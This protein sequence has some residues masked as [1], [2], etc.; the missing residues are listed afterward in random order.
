MRVAVAV[1]DSDMTGE[2]CGWMDLHERAGIGVE[3]MELGLDTVDGG[4]GLRGQGLAGGA[5]GGEATL[6]EEGDVIG[7]A[8]GEIDIMEYGADAEAGGSGELVGVS[9]DGVL[10]AQVEG[11]GWFIEQEPAGGCVRFVLCGTTGEDIELGENACEVHPLFFASG[12]GRVAPVG[13]TFEADSGEG[14]TGGVMI[15]LA[16]PTA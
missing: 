6:V 12:E 7:V 13:Q 15:G 3:V 2:C 1:V 16:L 5:G 11:G 4:N 10:M 8:K 14:T 9:E